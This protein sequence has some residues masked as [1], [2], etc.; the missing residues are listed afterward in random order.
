M[1]PLLWRRCPSLYHKNLGGG[2]PLHLMCQMAERFTL[3]DFEPA[4]PWSIDGFTA[5]ISNEGIRFCLLLIYKLCAVL[6]VLVSAQVWLSLTTWPRLAC[7]VDSHH[8]ELVPFALAQTWYSGL[9]LVN[10]GTTVAVIRH[11]S[12]KPTPKLVFFLHNVMS[13]GSTTIRLWFGPPQCD[14]LVVKISNVRL[15]GRA[16]WF[17]NE[18]VKQMQFSH[19]CWQ[20]EKEPHC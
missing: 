15:F 4:A 6:T 19:L 20:P 11:Q 9:K 10:D 3:T 12:V 18:N 14:R 13:D 2:S 8:S 17:C 7:F 5:Q 1:A 16:W